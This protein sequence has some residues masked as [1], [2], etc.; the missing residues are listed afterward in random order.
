VAVACPPRVCVRN[1]FPQ[2]G[3]NQFESPSLSDSEKLD[4]IISIVVTLNNLMVQE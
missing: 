3:S 4:G 1:I 2:L